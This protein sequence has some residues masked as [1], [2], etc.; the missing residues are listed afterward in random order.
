[1]FAVVEKP[2][3]G[4]EIPGSMRSNHRV[5]CENWPKPVQSGTELPRTWLWEVTPRGASPCSPCLCGHCVYTL[6]LFQ[7]KN[8]K[9]S[10][11]AVQIL[12]GVAG[13]VGGWG[14]WY[15]SF[16]VYLHSV[17]F[18]FLLHLLIYFEKLFTSSYKSLRGDLQ[19]LFRHNLDS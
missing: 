2:R 9:Y 4:S 11:N 5:Q 19:S 1:M 15:I 8:H 16:F 12:P 3:R 7:M 14:D 17:F 10:S 6:A 18:L 13:P